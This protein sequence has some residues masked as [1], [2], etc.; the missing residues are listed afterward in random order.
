M[1]RPLADPQTLLRTL[2]ARAILEA[3]ARRGPLTRAE[4]MGETGLSRTAV[5]QVLRMLEAGDAVASAG[6]DRETR[7]PAATRVSLHPGLGVA[8]AVHVD[9]TAMHVSLVDLTGSVRAQRDAPLGH[10]EDRAA[11]IAA[12]ITECR[13]AVHAP[14]RHVV[15][16][17]PGIVTPDG[18]IRDDQGPDGGAFRAALAAHLG[19]PVRI[20]NDVNLAALAEADSEVGRE[21]SSFTLLLIDE[22]LGAGTVLDGE[23]RR[24]AAGIAGE[25]L[26]LPQPPVPIGA[27]VLNEAVVEDLALVHGR[28]PADPLL[29]HL[30]AC[31]DGDEAAKA[32]VDELAR[33]IV[34]VAGSVTLVIDPQAFVLAGH[35]AHPSFVA[36]VHRA[37]EALSHLL[38][39]RFVT[40]AF[41]REATM[42]GAIGQA[43]STLR[44]F[45]F[46]RF[47]SPGGMVGR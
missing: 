6:V 27:P 18:E 37:A 4:L 35:A 34:V 23:L 14:L 21:L 1:T 22:G 3:L 33:R 15:V 45:S 40:S 2:N 29:V 25:V 20:E 7:G 26:Y 38:A 11:D 9:H 42:I 10:V 41:G 28:D 44:E 8:A 19:C 36:A 16:A 32:M 30:N 12:L 5:T 39:L 24:G 47:V 13:Q 31:A 17:M 46:S 43:A